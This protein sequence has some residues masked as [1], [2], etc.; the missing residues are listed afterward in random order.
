MN[1]LVLIVDDDADI[2]STLTELLELKGYGVAVAANGADALDVLRALNPELPCVILLDLMMPI[3]DGYQFRA[4][5]FEDP[6]AAVVPVVVVTA[7]ASIRKLELGDVTVLTKPLQLDKLFAALERHC[8]S[9]G[10]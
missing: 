7:G 3:M 9:S 10:E 6:N 4:R 5:Q 1:R 8:S 2:R